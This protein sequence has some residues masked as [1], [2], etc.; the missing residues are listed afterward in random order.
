MNTAQQKHFDALYQ[1]HINALTRQGKRATTIDAYARA[2]RRITAFFDK[3]PDQLSLN[4]IKAYFTSLIST[5]SW[6]TVKLD[7]NGLQFFYKHVLGKEW[8]WVNIVRPPSV[9]S[10]PD[11]LSAGELSRMINATREAR[12]QTFILTAYD[13][14]LRLGETLNLTIADIDAQYP[15]I[16]IRRGKGRKD[17]YLTLPSVTLIALRRY[18]SSHRNPKLIFPTGKDAAARAQAID[19]MDRGGIQKPFKAIAKSCGIQKHVHIHTLRHC[20]SAHLVEPG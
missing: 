4:D 5:H 2:V 12:Y 14:G 11:I 13:M 18:W 9:K 17:R 15:R 8:I 7:R 6:S 16:H 1:E 20:Y 10:L 3:C 19:P